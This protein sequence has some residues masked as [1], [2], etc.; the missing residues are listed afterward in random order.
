MDLF[1]HAYRSKFPN[2]DM[3][4]ALDGMGRIIDTTA[5][6]RTI[7]TRHSII[8][9]HIVEQRNAVVSKSQIEEAVRA[10]LTAF[11]N[12]QIPILVHH[13][14]TGHARVFK[15]IINRRFLSE[16]LELRTALSIY[17]DFEKLFELDGFFWQQY[18][19]CQSQTGDHEVSL[20]TL[21]HA[22]AIHQHY[23]IK[24]SLGA[25]SLTA[26]ARL[27]PDGLKQ[28]DFGRLRDE[29]RQLL[30][31]LHDEFGFE[32]DLSIATLAEI[33]TNISKKFDESDDFRALCE[34][35]HRELAFYIRDH[36]EMN[37][38]KRAYEK[39]NDLLLRAS[40]IGDPDYDALAEIES[41]SA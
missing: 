23:Q 25:A 5:N 12:Y 17:R 32:D 30:T 10:L 36:S 31:E 41:S 37:A 14:N 27:G 22:F 20:E 40:S 24:H 6:R 11:S 18:G 13:S 16:I 28:N 15:T 39:L 4:S 1:G 21:R 29:G 33:D 8:A 7:R 34:R 38:A 3:R 9:Q 2:G 35:Y 19:L 26:C